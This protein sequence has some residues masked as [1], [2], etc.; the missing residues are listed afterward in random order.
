MVKK[1]T[2]VEMKR[3]IHA[4]TITGLSLLLIS[5]FSLPA[6]AQSNPPLV[7]TFKDAIYLALRNNPALESAELDRVTEKYALVVAKNQFEPQVD[8]KASYNRTLTTTNDATTDERTKSIGRTTDI[9]PT[10]SLENHYGTTVTLAGDNTRGRQYYNPSL[11]LT[12]EQPLIQGFGKAVVD[13]AL[14]NA[15]DAELQNKITLKQTT[16]STINTIMTDYFSVLQSEKQLQVDEETLKNNELL[17]KNDQVQIAAGQTAPADIVQDQ[18]QVATAKA[19]IE[20]DLNFIQQQKFTLLTDLGIA[21][22]ANIELPQNVDLQAIE[23]VLVGKNAPPSI[24]IA[25]KLILANNPQYQYDGI[26]L[27]IFRRAL[28]QAKDQQKWTLDLTASE[29]AGAGSGGGQNASFPS[30]SNHRNHAEALGLALTVPVDDV[31]AKQSLIEAQIGLEKAE[32]A[33][34]NEKRSLEI[35][36]LNDSNTIKQSKTLINLDEQAVNLQKR[37]LEIAN[38]KRQAGQVSS[39]ELI[40]NQQYLTTAQTTL[41]N[42]TIDYLKT[43]QQLDQDLGITLDLLGI[44]IKD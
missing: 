14:N 32:I 26:G 42:A 22:D 5:L 43:L 13:A 30:L 15:I 10:I 20:N 27:R 44:K 8:L 29:E 17:V 21:S 39:A 33:Y 11:T 25:K 16:I 18:A 28:L 1:M 12:V 31:T 23:S 35:T 19:T 37:T 38:L 40:Q 6:F 34:T 3:I 9:T 4:I 2:V 41:V 24:A 7:L 36:A